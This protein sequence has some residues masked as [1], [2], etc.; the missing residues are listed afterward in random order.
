MM[1]VAPP[2]VG[3]ANRER[4]VA[5]LTKLPK[6]GEPLT[7]ADGKTLLPELELQPF[8]AAV[9]TTPA[10]RNTDD[11]TSGRTSGVDTSGSASVPCR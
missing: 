5:R 10:T 2:A 1:A 7:A 9:L 4:G 11:K 8:R 6:D 3:N